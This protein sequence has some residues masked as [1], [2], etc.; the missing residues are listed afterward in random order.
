MA[1]DGMAR[2]IRVAHGT[3]DGDTVF[4]MATGTV[5]ANPNINQIGGAAADVLSRAIIRAIKSAQAIHVGTCN[6]S[7][8]CE[9]FPQKCQE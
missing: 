9:Q 2:A 8:Y 1:D 6:V 4:A 5:T 7:S 3:G